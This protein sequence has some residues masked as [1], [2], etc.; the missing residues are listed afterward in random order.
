METKGLHDHFADDL[1]LDLPE[2]LPNIH[3]LRE[4]YN[5]GSFWKWGNL[6]YQMQWSVQTLEEQLRDE[7]NPH[8]LQLNAFSYSDNWQ[9]PDSWYLYAD[10][11]LVGFGNGARARQCFEESAEAF[12]DLC[13][14]RVECMGLEALSEREYWLLSRARDI[15][16]Y[17]SFDDGNHAAGGRPGRID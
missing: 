12:R 11:I 13:R 2:A 4:P 15:A 10:G 14:V 7:G 17:E 9:N 5:L 6:H 1:C 16:R 8:V 3:Y